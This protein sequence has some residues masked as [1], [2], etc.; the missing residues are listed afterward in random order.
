MTTMKAAHPQMPYLVTGVVHMGAIG[1][2]RGGGVRIGGHR[3][4]E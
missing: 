4:A 1:A 3:V 2:T